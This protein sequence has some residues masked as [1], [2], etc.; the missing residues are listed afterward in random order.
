MNRWA[1]LLVL[2]VALWGGDSN[3]KWPAIPPEVWAMKENPEAGIRDAVILENRVIIRRVEMEYLYRV[4]I[5]TEAG[6]K[7]AELGHF[8][9]NSFDIEGRV[10]YPDGKTTRFDKKQDFRTE[11]LE[12]GELSVKQTVF[13]PPGLTNDCVFEVSWKERSSPDTSLPS[14]M[15]DW[16]YWRFGSTYFTKSQSITLDRVPRV[17]WST[18]NSRGLALVKTEDKNGITLSLE[19]IPAHDVRVYAL[20]VSLDRPIFSIYNPPHSILLNQKAKNDPGGYWRALGYEFFRTIFEE[21]IDKGSHY[22]KFL[23]RLK[24]ATAS[25]PEREAL[26]I[27]KTT[28]D[29]EFIFGSNLT[30]A[31]EDKVAAL[32]PRDWPNSDDLNTIC[33]LRRGHSMGIA[34]LYYHLMKDLG[35]KP[36]LLLVR[37]KTDWMFKEGHLNPWQFSDVLFAFGDERNPSLILDPELRFAPMGLILP[38]F[39]G[40]E[41]LLMYPFAEWITQRSSIP[42]QLPE[43][44]KRTFQ[45]DVT[46]GEEDETF[47]VTAQF[48]GYPEYVER[49][50]YL[51]MEAQE[52]NRSLKERFEKS[53]KGASITLAEVK[54]VTQ[55][56]QPPTWKVEGVREAES[57]RT[58]KI[59][60]F[61]GQPWALSVPSSFPKKREMPIVMPYLQVHRATSRVT[62]PAGKTLI[63][64]PDLHYQNT[65]GSVFWTA[66]PLEGKSGLE[67]TMEVRVETF[68]AAPSTYEQL[69]E[70]LGWVEEV[71]QRCLTMSASTSEKR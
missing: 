32:K 63:A 45:Y 6:K 29:R 44:N 10:S 11:K 52:Q 4:R 14:R 62:C 7:A 3:K 41:G 39:Q 59:H 28:I 12:A 2:G 25:K 46:V 5:L 15:G 18:F 58:R 43:T 40:S 47:R 42:I 36:R 49:V 13:V 34:K 33:E 60:P 61:P 56:D 55:I 30:H 37:D 17:A 22:R 16:Q 24:E 67:I 71:H 51:S 23:A 21:M 53:L 35:Y 19:N 8:S 64:P 54:N 68:A 48:A 26:T 27:L 65:Y 70:F 57:G 66:T 50:H 1:W 20:P 38:G 9:E 69:K 31:E